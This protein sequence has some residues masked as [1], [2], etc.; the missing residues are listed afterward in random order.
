MEMVNTGQI[1]RIILGFDKAVIP[2]TT[3]RCL[4][5]HNLEKLKNVQANENWETVIPIHR[6]QMEPTMNST[7]SK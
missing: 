4:N 1:C 7:R 2:S 3:Q 5:A 6:L